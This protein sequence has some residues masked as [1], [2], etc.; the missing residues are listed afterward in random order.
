MMRINTGSQ[1]PCTSDF[2]SLP[3][4]VSIPSQLL[5]GYVEIGCSRALDFF[6]QGAFLRKLSACVHLTQREG[7]SVYGFKSGRM[8]QKTGFVPNQEWN[9]VGTLV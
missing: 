3:G 9:H 8:L 4:S 2:M 1:S 6:T 5:H 7:Y